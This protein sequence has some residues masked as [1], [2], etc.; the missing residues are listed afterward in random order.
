MNGCPDRLL[1]ILQSIHGRSK[2]PSRG[3]NSDEVLSII[4]LKY[5]DCFDFVIKN[6]EIQMK[7]DWY[8]I[9][10]KSPKFVGTKAG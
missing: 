9:D 10:L 8:K 7:H 1:V 2:M 6:F 3:E 5:I 4:D